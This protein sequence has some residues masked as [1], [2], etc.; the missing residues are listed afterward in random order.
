METINAQIIINKIEN[1]DAIW[2]Y[3]HFSDYFQEISSY[4]EFKKLLSAYNSIRG[5]NRL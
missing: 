5:T 3:E 2:L 1:S 4:K